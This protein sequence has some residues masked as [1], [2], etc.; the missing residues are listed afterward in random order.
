[1]IGIL[2][3][4]LAIVSCLL[5]V[6][7]WATPSPAATVVLVQPASPASST[8]EA[9]VRIRGEL[10]SAGFDVQ[11]VEASAV[12]ATGG[13]SSGWL[14]RLAAGHGADAVVALNDEQASDSVEVWATDKV[15]GK[16]I[17]RRVSSVPLSARAPETLA[18]RAIELLRATFLEIE[19]SA[20]DTSGGPKPAPPPEVARFVGMERQDEHVERFEIEVG[21]AGV[22]GF[23]G[24]GPAVMPIV[25]LGWGPRPWLLVHVTAAGLGT[26]PSVENDIGSARVAQQLLTLGASYRFREGKRLRPFLSLSS[27]FLHMTAEGESGSTEYQG[28][29]PEGWSFLLDAGLGLGLGLSDR[30]YISLAAHTQMAQPYPV[31]RFEDSVVAT[32]YRPNLLLSLTIGAWL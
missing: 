16:S 21:G 6:A 13:D 4:R 10:V 25:R 12:A 15:T 17:T 1:V 2:V 5:A 24:L 19:L 26:R 30:F 22:T 31:I 9:L 8:G 11:T 27:G 14:E 3:R 18:I 29:H 23:A 7:L 20:R 32:S 28:Y